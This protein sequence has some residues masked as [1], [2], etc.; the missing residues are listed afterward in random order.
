MSSDVKITNEFI[1]ACLVGLAGFILLMT[2]FL[3]TASN[4]HDSDK[5]RARNHRAEIEAC[6][7]LEDAAERIL[8][9]NEA[10]D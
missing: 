4:V 2:V 6:A 1:G 5:H 3:T 7:N 10:D 9:L 8:C